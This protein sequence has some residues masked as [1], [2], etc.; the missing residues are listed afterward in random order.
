MNRRNF[1]G[2][3]LGTAISAD[4]VLAS[5]NPRKQ[6]DPGLP[7]LLGGPI[8][9]RTN[10]PEELALEHVRLGYKAAYCPRVALTDRERIAAIEAAFHRHAVVIAEVG[11]W[12]NLLDPDPAKRSE[13]LKLVAEGLALADEVGALCCV[14]IAGSYNRERWDGPHPDNLSERFFDAAVEN[15]RKIIDAV[16][17]RRARFCYELMPYSLPNSPDAAQK[18]LRAV[19]RKSYAVHL[20]PCNLVNAPERLYANTSL[21][22]EC[23]D[24]L[25]PSIV[26]CHAKDIDWGPELPVHIREVRPGTGRL[27]YTTYLGRLSRLPQQPPLMLE[28]LPNAAEYDAARQYLQG[29]LKG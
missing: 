4:M 24:K 16:Q 2:V 10:D 20:D 11:R 17:P 6:Q 12:V 1:I 19:D 18:M 13:N 26:S 14:D 3:A 23:F 5:V 8:F 29:L 27:D 7:V 25:G 15:A 9:A 22:N 21:L 28:H